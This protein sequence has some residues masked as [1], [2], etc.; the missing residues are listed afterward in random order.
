MPKKDPRI[1]EL[2][3]DRWR[4]YTAIRETVTSPEVFIERVSQLLN[5]WYL[6]DVPLLFSAAD[7][8]PREQWFT[9]QA[10]LHD[11]HTSATPRAE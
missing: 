11:M 9:V 5:Q 8:A 7:D 10:D 2:V 3:A 1:A 4:Q 6:E